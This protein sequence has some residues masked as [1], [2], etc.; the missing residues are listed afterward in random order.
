M[1][2]TPLALQDDSAPVEVETHVESFLEYLRAAGYAER[3]LRKKRCTAEAF[4]RWI[5]H[6]QVAL[7]DL[8]ESH[9]AAFVERSPR[10]NDRVACE[11]AT[12]R[13]FLGHLRTEAGIPAIAP[14]ANS[15]LSETLLTSYMEYLSNKRGLTERSICIYRRFIRD[16]LDDRVARTGAA[17]PGDLDAAVVRDFL[18]DR[19]HVYG[20][21]SESIRLLATSLRSFLRFLFLRGETATDLSP[22]VPTVRKWRQAN[23][24]ASL[25]PEEVE[26]VLAV[27]DRATPGGRRD[28]AILLLLARLGVRAGEVVALELEDIRWRA[29]EIVVR[30]KGRIHDRL[31]LLAD[32]G[33]ALTA[34]LQKDRG[35]STSRRVF[36]RKLAPR[37]GL[38]GPAAVGYVVRVGLAGAG[39]RSSHRGAAHLFRHSLASR[40][41]RQGASMA[42]I[43]Q[44]LR[45]R[46]TSTTAIY[47][48]V[49]LGTL[50]GVARRW[51]G[52]GG[53]Q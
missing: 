11:L 43:S 48:K 51:P 38:A 53:A 25:S 3:T 7:V 41:I 14:Q 32:V 49:D 27:P 2:E 10:S 8:N 13:P 40:M 31:P 12:L 15:S 9:V 23:V 22:S 33:E 21:S 4:D 45:H 36:L 30:G 34:Y 19:A 18:L 28:F 50:R 26:Q 46:S 37:V 42:E 47:A 17:V 29:G 52:T 5:T 24:P 35:E 16:F 44:I 20:Q 1:T 39:L 6:E